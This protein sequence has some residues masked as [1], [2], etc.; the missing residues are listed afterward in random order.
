ML[1]RSNISAVLFSD[2]DARTYLLRYP[3][4]HFKR[5]MTA[6]GKEW[7]YGSVAGNGLT[8]RFE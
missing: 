8:L 3:H 4:A 2:A 6:G 5:E 7:T 1:T